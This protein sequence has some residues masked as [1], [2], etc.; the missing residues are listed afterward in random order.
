MLKKYLVSTAGKQFYITKFYINKIEDILR[1]GYDIH[2]ITNVGISSMIGS[3]DQSFINNPE[4]D[5]IF[6]KLSTTKKFSKGISQ[7]E[8][9]EVVS[10]MEG[11]INSSEIY[12]SEYI[13]LELPRVILYYE[14]HK[15]KLLYNF[16][17]ICVI[18][19]MS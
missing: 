9:I 16:I 1:F 8:A 11:V 2:L 13:K 14:S 10:R 19:Y 7:L 4:S 18:P 6:N 3:I 5:N 12:S 15:Y 17:K